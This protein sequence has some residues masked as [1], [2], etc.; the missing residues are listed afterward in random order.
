MR[1]GSLRTSLVDAEFDPDDFDYKLLKPGDS[2]V[3]GAELAMQGKNR[4]GGYWL[5]VYPEDPTV[6]ASTQVT[7]PKTGLPLVERATG[8]GNHHRRTFRLRHPRP[9]SRRRR[10]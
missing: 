7:D 9:Y 10:R 5:R 1:M 3:V 6:E 2:P 4:V 8:P